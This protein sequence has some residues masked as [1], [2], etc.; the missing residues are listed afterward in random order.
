MC[1]FIFLSFGSI[2]FVPCSATPSS[3]PVIN[4]L[5]LKSNLSF[6]MNLAH[7]ETKEAIAPFIS[8]APLPYKKPLWTVDL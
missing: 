8:E 2:L 3:S 6:L 1:C 7:A 4:K 5:K